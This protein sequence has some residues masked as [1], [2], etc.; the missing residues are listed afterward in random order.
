MTTLEFFN[1]V[2]PPNGIFYVVAIDRMERVRHKP[3]TSHQQMVDFLAQTEKSKHVDGQEV[4]LY[5]SCASYHEAKFVDE[6]GLTRYRK[7]PN[8]AQAKA[9]WADVDCGE[10]KA[11]K[12]KGYLT[13][14]DGWA[15]IKDFCAKVGLPLPTVVN[16]GNGIHIYWPLTEAVDSADWVPVARKFKALLDQ[17]NMIVDPS[18]TADFASVLRPPGAM[19]HKQVPLKV[20]LKRSCDPISFEQ[21]EAII[22]GKLAGPQPNYKLSTDSSINDD[23]LAHVASYPDSSA[24]E[25]ASKCKQLAKMRDTQ[26]D[27]GYMEWWGCLG[28]IK[29][30]TDAE[31]VAIKWSERR[32]ETGHSHVDAQAGLDS[33]NAGPTRCS[34]FSQHNPEGCK[35][36]E[37]SGKVQSPITLGRIVPEP[38]ESEAP[39]DIDGESVVVQIPAPPAGY[40]FTAN[41]TTRYLVDKDGITHSF[42]FTPLMLYATH[43]SVGESGSFS[44]GLRAHLPRNKIREFT[45]PTSTL[46]STSDLLKALGDKEIVTTSTK[47]AALHLTAYLK[48]SLAKLMAEADEINTLTSFGWHYDMQGFLIGDRLYHQDGTTRKVLVGGYAADLA[49]KAFPKPVGTIEGYARP[50]N[51]IYC[52]PGMEPFQYAICS[53]F[54]SLLSPL[55]E[56]GYSGL[57]LALTGKSGKGKSTVCQA[58]LYAFGDGKDAL[59]VAGDR[60]TGATDNGRWALL[61]AYK[62]IPMLFD[63]VTSMDPAEFSRMAYTVSL[64]KDKARINS[65]PGRLRIAQQNTWRMSPFATANKDIHA[66][67]SEHVGNSEAEAV[68]VVQIRTDRYKIPELPPDV[69]IAAISQ[70]RRNMGVAG[71]EFIKHIVVNLHDV[72]ELW[73]TVMEDVSAKIPG[74]KYRFYRNH[75]AC[76]LTALQITNELGITEFDYETVFNFAIHL[77]QTL[78]EDVQSNNAPSA[79]EAFNRMVSDL[80]PRI[81][82]TSEYRDARDKAGPENVYRPN[83]AIAGRFILGGGPKDTYAGHLYITF[84]E[85]RSWCGTQRV[86]FDEVMRYLEDAQAVIP[87]GEKFTITRGTNLPVVQQRVIGID[88]NKLHGISIPVTSSVVNIHKSQ[89]VA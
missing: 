63:E 36:C 18:R 81:I 8:W 52:R 89:Q 69:V 12:G 78:A 11:A 49:A 73:R 34:F 30:C 54:G 66:A 41:G 10:E 25:V 47:D 28:V 9:F 21:F 58:A 65:A 77:M 23:L 71:E 42:V 82:Q 87:T 26:G 56:D 3:L 37:F 75:A 22:D 76:T 2:L 40:G 1:A 46:A 19:N 64:G 5:F 38:T 67:L 72:C 29:H 14:K 85:F 79:E 7:K 53:G 86:D 48:D 68:R 39:A 59:T 32:Q 31:E 50:L 6:K 17:E 13:Q 80:T 74:A 55:G 16:S 4:N 57:L 33:W 61:G 20:V 51:E 45:I 27:L 44:L 84:K 83:A 62:N 15:A 88:T 35:G 70:M 60:I 43:R 24:V